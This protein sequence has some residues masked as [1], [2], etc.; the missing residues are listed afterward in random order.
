VGNLAHFLIGALAL[1][2]AIGGSEHR[3]VLVGAT[4]AYSLFALAFA[5]A[6]FTSPVSRNGEASE[7][8]QP[9]RS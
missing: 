3:A 6:L 8:D 4:V 1:G 2:K 5:V 9:R 7:G